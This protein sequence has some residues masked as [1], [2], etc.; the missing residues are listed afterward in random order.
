[1]ASRNITISMSDT[2]FFSEAMRPNIRRAIFLFCPDLELCYISNTSPSNNRININK[3]PIT[4]ELYYRLIG[5][6]RD[7]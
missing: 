4:R 6:V 2:N 1:M 3:Q 7:N 5:S